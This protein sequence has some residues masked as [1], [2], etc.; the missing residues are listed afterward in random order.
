MSTAVR[1]RP[2]TPSRVYQ[3]DI[4]TR[5][6][7]ADRQA[8]IAVT[9]RDSETNKSQDGSMKD[10]KAPATGRGCTDDDNALRLAARYGDDIRYCHPIGGW[11]VWDGR[12]W[13][14][15]QQ[16]RIM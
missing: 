2:A 16:G 12:R 8:G 3:E 5:T 15:D 7:L 14:L 11:F 6:R 1:N 13:V 10:K 9:D 4:T